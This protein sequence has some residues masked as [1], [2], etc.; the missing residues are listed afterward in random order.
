MSPFTPAELDYLHTTRSLARIATLG[1]DGT[2]H[3]TPVGWSLSPDEQAIDITGRNFTAT[4]KYKDVARTRRAAVVIDAVDEPWRPHGI[5]IRGYAEAHDE[6][7]A[8]IRIHPSRI[9]SWGFDGA[10]GS[11]S[12]NSSEADAHDAR[13]AIVRRISFQPDVELRTDPH[14]AEFQRVHAAQPGYR[15]NLIIDA[16]D[17][18]QLTVTVWDTETDSNNARGALGSAIDQL[19]VPMLAKPAELLAAGAVLEDELTRS[20]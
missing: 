12:I 6:P 11:R 15:G 9:I 14:I 8:R 1:P 18:T 5:E 2:P 10:T 20:A 4:R 19:V 3:V 17:N 13:W 7:D 16:G